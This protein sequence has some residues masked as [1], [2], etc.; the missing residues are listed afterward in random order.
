MMRINEIELSQGNQF[1]GAFDSERSYENYDNGNYDER[2][3]DQD[4]SELPRVNRGE[5]QKCFRC[6]RLGHSHRNCREKKTFNYCYLCGEKDVTVDTCPKGH[7]KF[8]T[9]YGDDRSSKNKY[10]HFNDQ[11]FSNDENADDRHRSNPGNG[12]LGARPRAT[13]PQ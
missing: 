2:V 8:R 11:N 3:Y 9:K 12:V 1:C 6:G 13:G 10:V 5:P 7:Y 4:V